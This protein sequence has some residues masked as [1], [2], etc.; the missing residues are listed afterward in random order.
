MKTEIHITGQISGNIRLRNAIITAVC[1]E[2]RGMFNSYIL[3]F[4]SNKAAVKALSEGYQYMSREE[5][6]ITNRI[7]GINY[8]RGHAL[9]YDASRAV[10]QD[11]NS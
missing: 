11:N 6:R 4:K 1:E 8:S 7:G 2:R 3:T 9:N 10:I 5:P